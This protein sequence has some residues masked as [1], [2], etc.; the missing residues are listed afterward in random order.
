M[1]DK[2]VDTAC[3]YAHLC[4]SA[5]R[6]RK[7]NVE[8]A[9]LRLLPSCM[10]IWFCTKNVGPI[11]I[12]WDFWNVE[13]WETLNGRACVVL[14]N[15]CIWFVFHGYCL[16]VITL[17]GVQILHCNDLTLQPVNKLMLY[18]GRCRISCGVLFLLLRYC[19]ELIKRTISNSCTCAG[20][21]PLLDSSSSHESVQYCQIQTCLALYGNLN[22][23]IIKSAIEQT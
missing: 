11:L 4:A 6:Y 8:A 3:E 15:F 18:G 12:Y 19:R 22:F 2:F 1:N 13:C 10:P 5:Q 17:L 21:G 20:G 14:K 7:C 9:L 16:L 23:G